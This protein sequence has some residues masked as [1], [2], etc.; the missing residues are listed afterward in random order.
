MQQRLCD[1]VRRGATILYEGTCDNQQSLPDDVCACT[2]D[3]T[4]VCGTHNDVQSTYGNECY[5]ECEYVSLYKCV[6][7]CLS[8]CLSV[9]TRVSL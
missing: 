4:P 8:V 9:C 5:A 7:V 2:D 3:Y 6:S 1:V